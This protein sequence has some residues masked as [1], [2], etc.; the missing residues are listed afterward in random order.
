VQLKR[1]D[2]SLVP[3]LS[4]ML[5]GI[6]STFHPFE[7]SPSSIR[8]AVKPEDEHWVITSRGSGVVAYGMLRGWADGWEVPALGIAVDL[9]YRRKGIASFM[10][11]FLHYRAKER[12]ARRVMLHVSDGHVAAQSLYRSMGYQPTLDKW[13]CEL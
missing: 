11:M 4:Q 13:V 10:I 7:P 9:M 6:E 5:Q 8:L 1:L 2:D 3:S 12:G